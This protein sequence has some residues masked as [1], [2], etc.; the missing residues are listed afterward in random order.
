MIVPARVWA[1]R[2]GPRLTRDLRLAFPQPVR[3]AGRRL[4]RD[5]RLRPQAVRE[6]RLSGRD[7][8]RTEP[9]LVR[10]DD[11]AIALRFVNGQPVTEEQKPDGADGETWAMDVLVDRTGI[12]FGDLWDVKFTLF[13]V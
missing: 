10:I 6:H 5:H 12:S 9:H 8:G 1:A 3:G 13:E 11:Q 2:P 7:V 4:G